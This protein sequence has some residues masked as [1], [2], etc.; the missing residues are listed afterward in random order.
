MSRRNPSVLGIWGDDGVRAFAS[1][2]YWAAPAKWNDDARRANQ[3]RRVFCGSLMDCWEDR[4]ELL[5][6]RERLLMT[7]YLCNQLDWLFLT[8]RPE[9]IQKCLTQARH[10]H[11]PHEDWW[12]LQTRAARPNWWFGTSVEDQ[13]RADLRIPILAEVPAVVRFLSVEPLL[14][15]LDLR[16]HL[17]GGRI[18]WVII[19]GES[20]QGGKQA[21]EL[22]LEW[23]K[24]LVEQCAETHTACFVKQAGS[25]P[26]ADGLGL[27]LKDHHGGNPAEWPSWMRVRQL[28]GVS[29]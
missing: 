15:P 28:P 19:G 17:A 20:S 18:H 16:A 13:T 26:I 14:G 25:R 1:E 29:A 7:A 3:S 5:E 12:S 2:S 22:H 8:K 11:Y 24:D 27:I 9:N 21:R 23:V 6:H 4:P 10:K